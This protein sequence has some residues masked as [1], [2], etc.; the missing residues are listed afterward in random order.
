[1]K[2]KSQREWMGFQKRCGWKCLGVKGIDILWDLTDA[3]DIYEQEK[4][5]MY[6]FIKRRETHV[7][8]VV[9]GG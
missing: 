5:Q 3:K 4:I 8:V 9:T 6:H 1:M 7:I 2:M